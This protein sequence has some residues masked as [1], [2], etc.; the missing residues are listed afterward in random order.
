VIVLLEAPGV[1]QQCGELNERCRIAR[2]VQ[3]ELERQ[4][5]EMEPNEAHRTGDTEKFN[6]FSLEIM[7]VLT[8]L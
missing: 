8:P 7:Y 1:I 4:R 5:W 3:Y 6:A 2:D